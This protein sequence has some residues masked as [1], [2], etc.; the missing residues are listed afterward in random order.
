MSELPLPMYSDISEPCK[1]LL[2]LPFQIARELFLLI[3]LYNPERMVQEPLPDGRSS[4]DG[5]QQC[6]VHSVRAREIS[7]F[8]P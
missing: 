5:F 7:L 4:E 2:Y 1:Y 6:S 3:D 8:D